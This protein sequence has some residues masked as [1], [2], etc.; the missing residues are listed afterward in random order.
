MALLIIME[1]LIRSIPNDYSYKK[2]YLDKYSDSVNVLLLGNSHTYYGIIPSLMQGK[3]FNASHS[4]QTLYCDKAIMEKYESNWKSLKYIVL[5]LDYNSLVANSSKDIY[6]RARIGYNLY[7]GINV[8]T[9]LFDY[10]EFTNQSPV[11]SVERIKNYYLLGNS[12]ITCTPYGFRYI[13]RKQRSLS[14][15]GVKYAAQHTKTDFD[16]VQTNKQNLKSIIDFASKNNVN[17]LL[18]SAPAYKT[19][20]KMIDSTQLSIIIEEGKQLSQEF[21]NVKYVNFLNDTS[22]VEYDYFD[23]N[24]LNKSGA[25]KL[26]KRINCLLNSD[27]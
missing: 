21:T 7:Y 24:H 1:G 11:K 6:K 13:P 25:I 20:V 18:Y 22:F 2:D 10:F 12:E 5:S 26:T 9:N 27:W 19:Y 17:V 14:S 16:A 15:T 4:S 3:V 8:S 23:A